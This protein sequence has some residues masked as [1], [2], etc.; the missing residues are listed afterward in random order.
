MLRFIALGNV[1][2]QCTRINLFPLA[3]KTLLSQTQHLFISPFTIL[4]LSPFFFALSHRV[5]HIAFSLPLSYILA[6]K[7]CSLLFLLPS[8][9]SSP[10]F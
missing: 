2:I 10:S 1:P 8:S 9:S 3:I 4:S 5:P 7:S 6:P